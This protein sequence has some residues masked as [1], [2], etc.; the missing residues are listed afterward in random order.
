MTGNLLRVTTD[1]ALAEISSGLHDEWFD[2]DRVTHDIER[3]EL[4]VMIYPGRIT[5]RIIRVT[6]PP[7]DRDED[8]PL[9]IGELVV[10]Q[11]VSVEIRDDA[12]IRWYDVGDLRFDPGTNRLTLRS[13]FPL[14]IS[15][16]VEGLDV[17]L[18]R[19]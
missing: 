1:A 7:L 2:L 8:L 9:P 17:D 16:E 18:L 5:G 15:V 4:R 10:R 12:E 6:R 14:E 3:R 11:V 13:N 19:P